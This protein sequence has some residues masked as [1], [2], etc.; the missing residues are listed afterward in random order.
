MTTSTVDATQEL[1]AFLRTRRER[2]DPDEFGLPS[3]RRSR[4]TPGL[5]RE[6]VA[7]LAGVSI[8]Y[9]VRLEQGRG[10]RPSADVVEAL[11]RALRLAPDERA[12]LFDLARQRPRSSDKPATTAPPPLARLVADLA[13]LPAMLFNHRYDILAWNREMARLLLDFDTLPP[14]QRNVMWLCLMHPLTR[15]FYA[16]RE[17]VVREGVAHLRAAWAAHPEDR[18]LSDLIAEFTAHDEEFAH[19]WAERDVKV[20]GRGH[21]VM[22][23]PEVGEVAVHYEVLA[24]LQDPDQRLVIY[25]AADGESQAALDRLSA[26]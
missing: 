3:R 12:Y 18:V 4:R 19:W 9:V 1:A 17:R 20:N 8:D 10:L 11:S 15:E 5:R 24:P 26:P 22:R 7:E 13:P 16:D 21:K 6:E 25:R 23:H 2:L 14:T